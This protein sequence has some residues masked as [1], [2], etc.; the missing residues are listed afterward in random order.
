M[1]S[2]NFAL[3]LLSNKNLSILRLLSTNIFKLQSTLL[4]SESHKSA[5]GFCTVM[6]SLITVTRF[7]ICK[8]K[9]K[10]TDNFYTYFK[11]VSDHECCSPISKTENSLSINKDNNSTKKM[12]IRYNLTSCIPIIFF[13]PQYLILDNQLQVI[14]RR[15]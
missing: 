3:F 5:R 10:K 2:I 6:A 4:N 1:L 15:L 13:N 8:L 7:L 14:K 12:P 9:K 11:K